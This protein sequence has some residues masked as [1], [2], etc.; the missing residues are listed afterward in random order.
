MAARNSKQMEGEACRKVQTALILVVKGAN[1]VRRRYEELKLEKERLMKAQSCCVEF[2]PY[3][4]G[5][6]KSLRCFK[7]GNDK[8]R[9]GVSQFTSLVLAVA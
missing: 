4:S 7:Q 8:I 5:N 3:I 1:G 9:F 6:R 2:A